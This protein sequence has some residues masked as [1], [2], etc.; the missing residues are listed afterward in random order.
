MTVNNAIRIVTSIL[1]TFMLVLTA[2][3][4][5]S[6][7]EI[8]HKVF[9]TSETYNGNLGGLEGADEICQNSGEELGGT[10]KA[11]LSTPTVNAIDRLPNVK[12][13]RTGD[14]ALVA[15]NKQDILINKGGKYVHNPINRDEYGNDASKAS[16]TI[17]WTGTNREGKFLG[18]G[19][20]AC[21]SWTSAAAS[22]PSAPNGAT[23]G[24]I[25]SGSSGYQWT[26]QYD[27]FNCQSKNRIYCFQTELPPAPVIDSI[28]QH[29]TQATITGENF[30]NPIVE[31][32]GVQAEVI[33]Y[34]ENEI[35]FSLPEG[36][37]GEADAKVTNSDGQMSA[38]SFIIV[39]PQVT[40][41]FP[42]PSTAGVSV[43]AEPQITFNVEIDPETVNSGTVQLRKIKTGTLREG[44]DSYSKITLAQKVTI[45]GTPV[46]VTTTTLQL[47]KGANIVPYL[48]QRALP[49]EAALA[50]VIQK[51]G[52]V[53][54]VNDNVILYHKTISGLLPTAPMEP[55][56]SYKIIMDADAELVYPAVET[57]E[58]AQ[59][60]LELNEGWNIPAISIEMQDMSFEN[61]FKDVQ[62]RNGDVIRQ[63]GE[64][65]QIEATY[66][67]TNGE[68]EGEPQPTV[69]PA[70][71]YQIRLSSGVTID[72]TGKTLVLKP[73]TT[74]SLSENARRLVQLEPNTEYYLW[75]DGVKDA[76]GNDANQ[77]IDEEAQKFR[78]ED[79]L[80]VISQ[81]PYPGAA[82]SSVDTLPKITL[83]GPVK[84][85]TVNSETV[86]I[87]EFSNNN[88]VEAEVTLIS[89]GESVKPA[90]RLTPETELKPN[91]YYYLWASGV[92]DENGLGVDYTAKELQLF[93]T[94]DDKVTPKGFR[95]TQPSNGVITATGSISISGEVNKDLGGVEVRAYPNTID[96]F[97][98][99][100]R[101]GKLDYDDIILLHIYLNGNDP[102]I[103]GFMLDDYKTRT[104]SSEIRNFLD[105]FEKG[106]VEEGEVSMDIDQNGLTDF[107]TDI[108]LLFRRLI[109]GASSN[110]LLQEGLLGEGAQR[111]NPD[112]LIAYMDMLRQRSLLD[113][114]NDAVVGTTMVP[115]GQT[116]WTLNVLLNDGVNELLLVAIDEN[117]NPTGY[118]QVTATAIPASCATLQDV[119]SASFGSQCG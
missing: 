42:E 114:E 9:V 59:L 51:V 1:L 17:V 108:M 84:P 7:Q 12:Y 100:D 67:Y 44:D 36:I 50:G 14:G 81:S 30:N 45:S 78:T 52:Q 34:T 64:G 41:Q 91:T 60:Q 70:K 110:A 4:T 111:T 74:L 23:A 58:T 3:A 25:S 79:S 98:D 26:L 6:A 43:K 86:Q 113:L 90:I 106:I 56:K 29:N 46:D 76:N 102:I 37:E 107:D 40:S 24:S 105:Q 48:P 72:E 92:E 27:T 75:M 35:T 99:V 104:D 47:K 80:L 19:D 77:Y 38:F 32:N 21:N 13:V 96:A 71:A 16:D 18:H 117:N 88:P 33:S 55:G 89:N 109:L 85:E 103:P 63:I 112:E 94:G 62:F 101:N 68:W 54:N 118:H 97:L 53:T 2:I 10:W 11:W 22:T 28:Q 119:I 69:N 5:A 95:I 83:S 49:I 61:V 39:F 82:E 20:A 116:E 57:E 8:P 15:N 73:R 65:N 87:R 31:V 115:A 93:R 66:T